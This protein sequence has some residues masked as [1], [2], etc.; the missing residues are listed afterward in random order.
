MEVDMIE[1]GIREFRERL[2]EVVN[3]NEFVVIKNNGKEVGTY[4][5][6]LWKRDLAKARLAADQVKM[7][8]Q[9]LQSKGVDLDLEMKKLGMTP[10]GEPLND[11]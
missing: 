11:D 5:P 3:G 4:M 2:S 9:E 8:R 7:A 6:V 10:I 1:L